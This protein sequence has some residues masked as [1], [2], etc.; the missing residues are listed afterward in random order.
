M[1]TAIKDMTTAE[2]HAICASTSPSV[3]FTDLQ[4]RATAELTRREMLAQAPAT[5]KSVMDNAQRLRIIKALKVLD[6]IDPVDG[7]ESVTAYGVAHLASLFES[8][9]ATEAEHPGILHGLCL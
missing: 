9:P 3:Q 4:A 8:M 7:N 5:F 1:H 2:L 6:V